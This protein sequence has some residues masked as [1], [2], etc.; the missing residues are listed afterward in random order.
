MK[1]KKVLKIAGVFVLA[2][3]LAVPAFAGA[4]VGVQGGPSFGTTQDITV[5]SPFINNTI[6]NT[7]IRTGFTTGLIVGYDFVNQGY[8]PVW[9]EWA[10]YF[11][12]T[13][14][15]GYTQMNFSAQTRTLATGQVIGFSNADGGNTA[16]TF[17]LVGRLP[18]MI[19]K[20]YPA[21]RFQP[22]PG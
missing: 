5:T 8:G 7:K 1:L 22:G 19:E 2:M 4:W 18:L 6:L 14:D 16:L 21:G 3:G 11:G 12:V 13:M 17:M 20:D 15:V 10:K 9:P